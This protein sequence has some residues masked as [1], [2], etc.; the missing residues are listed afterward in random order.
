MFATLNNPAKRWPLIASLFANS[1]VL[2]V[3]ACNPAHWLPPLRPQIVRGDVSAYVLTQVRLPRQAQAASSEKEKAA[4]PQPKPERQNTGSTASA[5]QGTARWNALAAQGQNSDL[6][7]T[8]VGTLPLIEARQVELAFDSHRPRGDTYLFDTRTRTISYGAMPDDVVVRELELAPSDFAV[9][10]NK[11]ARYLGEPPR[12]FALY[13]QSLFAVMRAL[14]IEALRHSGARLDKIT[15][16][17]IRVQLIN[18]QDF[19]VTLI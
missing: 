11:A 2:L 1:L 7:I 5:V 17:R 18:Q 10:R 15:T 6:A 9:E 4:A 19:V 14:T 8:A 3:L 16:V 12:V 13:P